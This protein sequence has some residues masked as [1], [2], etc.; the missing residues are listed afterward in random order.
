MQQGNE[1]QTVSGILAR[2]LKMM[3]MDGEKGMMTPR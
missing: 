1:Q 3:Q 2:T